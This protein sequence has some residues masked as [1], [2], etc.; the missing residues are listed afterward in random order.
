MTTKIIPEAKE[1]RCD[2]CTRVCGDR[3]GETPRLHATVLSVQ[4]HAVDHQNAPC[5]DASLRFDL[6]DECAKAV[7]EGINSA[8]VRIQH[9]VGVRKVSP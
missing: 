1:V 9:F 8:A 7:T 3:P 2:V 4:R 6:C 5:A